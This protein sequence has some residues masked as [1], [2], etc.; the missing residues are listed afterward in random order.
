M[1]RPDGSIGPAIFFLERRPA[2]VMVCFFEAAEPSAD[3]SSSGVR[4]VATFREDKPLRYH[5]AYGPASVEF[6]ARTTRTDR[7]DRREPARLFRSNARRQDAAVFAR[8]DRRAGSGVG[9]Q[10]Q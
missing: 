5:V 7:R 8:V 4:G 6:R 3:A 10:L 1:V 9:R 2:S